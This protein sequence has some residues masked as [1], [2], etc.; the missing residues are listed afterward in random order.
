ML[1]G[2]SECKHIACGAEILEIEVEFH[3][4]ELLGRCTQEEGCGPTVGCRDGV[5]LRSKV[6]LKILTPFKVPYG[7]AGED[8]DS[9][10]VDGSFFSS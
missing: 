8:S 2:Y 10:R 9:N 4:A 6:T 3:R 7:R 1:Y 5:R